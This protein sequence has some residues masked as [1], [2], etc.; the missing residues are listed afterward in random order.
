MN[1]IDRDKHG[2]MDSLEKFVAHNIC[3]AHGHDLAET[4]IP[5]DPDKEVSSYFS[6]RASLTAAEPC[7]EINY[8]STEELKKVLENIWANEPALKNLAPTLAALACMLE[9]NLDLD[10]ELPSFVYTL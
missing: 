7:F 9:N 1:S 10:E 6:P 5:L 3:I 2:A 8:N 4:T